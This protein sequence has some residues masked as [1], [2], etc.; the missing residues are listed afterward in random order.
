MLNFSEELHRRLHHDHDHHA[1][2]H[3]HQLY[4]NGCH[5]REVTFCVVPHIYSES[6]YEPLLDIVL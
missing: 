2:R 3:R 4:R 1:R 5:N 6:Y